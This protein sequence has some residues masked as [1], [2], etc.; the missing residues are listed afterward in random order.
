MISVNFKK[1]Y[2][3]FSGC[4]PCGTL[5]RTFQE[6][7]YKGDLLCM[8]PISQLGDGRKR[9]Y[10]AEYTFPKEGKIF[11]VDAVVVGFWDNEVEHVI[12]GL[13]VNAF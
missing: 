12:N 9:Y 2:N 10:I 4:N 13:K 8:M 6:E 1:I 3:N 7:K 5:E 11:F